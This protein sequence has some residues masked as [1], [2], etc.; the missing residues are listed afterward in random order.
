[1]L[2]K[3]GSTKNYVGFNIRLFYLLFRRSQS[4][5]SDFEYRKKQTGRAIRCNLFEAEKASKRISASIPNAGLTQKTA[6]DKISIF[7]RK[8]QAIPN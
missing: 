5:S 7:I 1:M 2:A 4:A 3:N 8:N 6:H